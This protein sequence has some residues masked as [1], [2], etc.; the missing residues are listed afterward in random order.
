MLAS[1]AVERE[2]LIPL[3]SR[4]HSLRSNGGRV[5]SLRLQGEDVARFTRGALHASRESSARSTCGRKTNQCSLRSRIMLTPFTKERI[6]RRSGG[7][8]H[9]TFRPR[10]R[11]HCSLHLREGE[12]CSLH[13]Q[14]RQECSLNSQEREDCSP[15]LREN[16][17]LSFCSRE[18]ALFA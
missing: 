13:S 7:R 6:A 16:E 4:G 18:A 1:L 9:C 17:S 12:H 14:E 2:M 5:S 10:E 3:T 11:Q 8:Q 15:H